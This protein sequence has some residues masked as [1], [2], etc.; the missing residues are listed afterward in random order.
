MGNTPL[1]SCIIPA[2]NAEMFISNCIE[3]VLRQTYKNFEVIIVDDGSQDRTGEICDAFAMVDCRV[4][5][6]HKKNMGVSAARNTGIMKA[7]G[8][9]VCFLDADDWLCPNIFEMCIKNYKAKKINVWGAT[10]HLPNGKKVKENCAVGNS[11][12]EELIANAIY[13]VN[14]NVYDLGT[15]FRA[16]WGKL[17][18]KK[19]LD[20]YKLRFPEE[21]YMGEDAVFLIDYLTH[22]S[23][24]NLIADDGYNYNRTNE[25]SATSKYHRDLYEQNVLQYEK[26]LDIVERENLQ[27]NEIVFTS[28]VNFRWWMMTTLI[29]NSIKGIVEKKVPLNK[30]LDQSI[31]W[32]ASY[33]EDMKKTVEDDSYICKRYLSL[34][35]H[36]ENINFISICTCYVFPRA[37]KKISKLIRN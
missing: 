25:G 18:E 12:R 8:D 32:F 2:Y 23:G 35:L 37:L 6:I 34:Y 17:F 5:A 31:Q 15:F 36:R 27:K 4:H 26:I 7:K 22:V 30:L 20:Q 21:M 29:D 9:L 28:L 10:S 11:S 24:I 33:E 13:K 1:I 19:I 14:S 16:V 3:S